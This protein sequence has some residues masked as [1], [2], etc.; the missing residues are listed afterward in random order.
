MS[1][2]IDLSLTNEI[3]FLQSTYTGLLS[4]EVSVKG[5]SK[6]NFTDS[7]LIKIGKAAMSKSANPKL[8]KSIWKS[9]IWNFIDYENREFKK[10]K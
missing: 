8:I 7:I 1:L 3:I 2:I 6:E 9:M 5:L 10:R 4:P